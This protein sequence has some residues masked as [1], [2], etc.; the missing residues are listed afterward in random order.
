MDRAARIQTKAVDTT[1]AACGTIQMDGLAGGNFI[2][3][4]NSSVTLL[5]WYGAHADATANYVPLYKSDKTAYTDTVAPGSTGGGYV[6]DDCVFGY[7]NLRAVANAAGSII[8]C[9]KS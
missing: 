4:A 8:V 6:L 2:V 1:L 5:T 7:P 9:P 3:P